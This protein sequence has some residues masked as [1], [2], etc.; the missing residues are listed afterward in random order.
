MIYLS[1]IFRCYKTSFSI[2]VAWITCGVQW[3]MSFCGD[4]WQHFLSML[5]LELEIVWLQDS[6]ISLDDE[7]ILCF[8]V[9]HPKMP[10]STGARLVILICWTAALV[11]VST[12]CAKL[13]S[14]LAVVDRKMPFSNLKE[15]LQQDADFYVFGAGHARDLFSVS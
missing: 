14:Y 9:G 2:G 1:K 10:V 8:S 5:R 7:D 3:R 11:L 15:A 6:K 13:T 4:W 12:F